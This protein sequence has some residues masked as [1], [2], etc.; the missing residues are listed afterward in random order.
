MLG[1]DLGTPEKSFGGGFGNALAE[2]CTEGG[3]LGAGEGSAA[4]S[5]KTPVA[6]NSL[7]GAGQFPAA[8]SSVLPQ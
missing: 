7:E 8:V 4:G 6:G 3:D 1:G 5:A 2:G